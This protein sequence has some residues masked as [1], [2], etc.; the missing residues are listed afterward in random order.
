MVRRNDAV[1]VHDRA[2]T[3]WRYAVETP[4]VMQSRIYGVLQ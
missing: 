1:V 3:D 2:A 4:G